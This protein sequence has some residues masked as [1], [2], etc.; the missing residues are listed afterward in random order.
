MIPTIKQIREGIG[1]EPVPITTHR[2]SQGFGVENTFQA[3]LHWYTSMGMLGHNGLDYGCRIGTK[4]IA[5]IDVTVSNFY[6]E[7]QSPDYGGALWLRSKEFKIENNLYAIEIVMAHLSGFFPG[8]I[9]GKT[10]KQGEECCISGNTGK[11]TTGAHCHEGWRV[12]QKQSNGGWLAIN[13]DNGYKGY[14]NQLLLMKKNMKLIKTDNSPSIYL[15]S[16]DNKYKIKLIDMPTLESLKQPAVT[17]ITV[18]EMSS[19]LPG[20]TMVWTERSID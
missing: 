9:I 15:L 7:V 20:G 13:K 4:L 5:P 3:I 6:N 17:V 2:V 11:Y 10:Y 1:Q 14:F 16:D 12:T 18:A 8:I 19:Y